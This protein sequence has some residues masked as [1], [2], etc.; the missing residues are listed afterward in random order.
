MAGASRARWRPWNWGISA[1][2]AFVAATV[3]FLT[4]T[5]AGAGLAAVLYRSMLSGIDSTAAAR[6]ADVAVE[7]EADGVRHMDPQVL[8]TDERILGVPLIPEAHGMQALVDDLAAVGTLA[9]LSWITDCPHVV[10][11]L[12]EGRGCHVMTVGVV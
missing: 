12:D 11:C 3:V 1:R 7:V 10:Y 5:L 2:S 4:L 6:V 8:H 9:R